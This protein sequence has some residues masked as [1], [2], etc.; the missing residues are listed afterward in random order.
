MAQF[1]LRSCLEAGWSEAA[2]SL[3]E[4]VPGKH[5]VGPGVGVCVLVLVGWLHAHQPLGWLWDGVC[6]AF[7]SRLLGWVVLIFTL[8]GSVES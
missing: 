6:L 8:C 5:S 1:W 2:P 7:R 3:A 4:Q